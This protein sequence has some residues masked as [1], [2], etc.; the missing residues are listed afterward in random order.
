MR[1]RL[2]R[3]LPVT[4]ASEMRIKMRAK[5]TRN[6]V[7]MATLKAGSFT[8]A[9]TRITIW[10]GKLQLDTE[11]FCTGYIRTVWYVTWCDFK[12]GGYPL[13][14]GCPITCTNNIATNPITVQ[15]LQH[16]NFIGL[17]KIDWVVQNTNLYLIY[18][19]SA[20]WPDPGSR[21]DIFQLKVSKNSSSCHNIQ[22]MVK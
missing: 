14:G 22:N 17:N 18:I 13:H 4:L 11:K 16:E 10:V 6:R 8:A 3:A 9:V 21:W 20:T 7:E 12:V 5:W 1:I 15:E 2:F 19:I